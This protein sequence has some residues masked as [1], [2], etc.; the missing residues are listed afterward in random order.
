MALLIWHNIL[1]IGS[2]FV[3]GLHLRPNSRT[4]LHEAR[5]YIKGYT[6]LFE[7]AVLDITVTKAIHLVD[8]VT[9]TPGWQSVPSN[10]K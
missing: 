1:L 5:M 6:Q 8:S 9:Q 7:R 4:L 10:D 2:L 3:C